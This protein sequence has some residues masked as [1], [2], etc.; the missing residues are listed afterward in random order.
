MTRHWR[1][2]AKLV[3]LLVVGYANYDLAAFCS[4]SNVLIARTQS[5]NAVGCTSQDENVRSRTEE[6]A[7]HNRSGIC[8]WWAEK[9]ERYLCSNAQ[10]C[11]TA[12]PHTYIIQTLR[13]RTHS[14]RCV[15]VYV[16]C[17]L[18]RSFGFLLLLF[19][20]VAAPLCRHSIRTKLEHSTAH[21]TKRNAFAW[22][23]RLH[24]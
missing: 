5:T 24:V 17:P 7:K 22:K 12:L 6:S 14:L 2:V 21:R 18:V 23:V 1:Y 10:N 4:F 3:L 19:C 9:A 15:C 16:C 8:I 13:T 20:M 11:E